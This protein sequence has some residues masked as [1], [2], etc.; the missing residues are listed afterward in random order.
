M[1]QNESLACQQLNLLALDALWVD[2]RREF[3]KSER[4]GYRYDL[5]YYAV[6]VGSVIL[7]V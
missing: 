7:L 4:G 6:A 3:G 1:D 5:Y 2:L